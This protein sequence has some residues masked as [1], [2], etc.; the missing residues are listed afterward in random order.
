MR[1]PADAV[2][3]ISDDGL[4]HLAGLTALEYL[5]LPGCTIYGTGLEHL[6]K[7]PRL[8][9]LDL[10]GTQVDDKAADALAALP[11][12]AHHGVP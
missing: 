11:A 9:T 6:A 2:A 1:P 5:A 12:L 8:A 4:K 3:G 7:L 10:A